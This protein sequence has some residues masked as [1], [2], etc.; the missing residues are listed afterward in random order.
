MGSLYYSLSVTHC[1]FALI[2]G[3][4]AF[5]IATSNGRIGNHL[6]NRVRKVGGWFRVDSGGQFI[7]GI[8]SSRPIKKKG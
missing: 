7:K 1:A 4:F 3:S 6:W 2:F 8:K 5:A